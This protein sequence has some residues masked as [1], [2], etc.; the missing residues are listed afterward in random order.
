MPVEE[1]KGQ[2]RQGQNKALMWQP[3]A[4]QGCRG[5]QP[6]QRGEDESAGG[7]GW[8]GR[9]VKATLRS[10]GVGRA[11]RPAQGFQRR[12][13]QGHPSSSAHR[14]ALHPTTVPRPSHARPRQ[15]GRHLAGRWASAHISR[16]LIS[17]ARRRRAQGN[18]CLNPALHNYSPSAWQTRPVSEP[19]DSKSIRK[20]SEKCVTEAPGGLESTRRDHSSSR[21]ARGRRRWPCRGPG[22]AVGRTPAHPSGRPLPCGWL[23][24][25]TLDGLLAL[26][27]LPA[28]LG[29]TPAR[30]HGSRTASHCLGPRTPGVSD[31][32]PSGGG[33][34]AT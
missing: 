19:K 8:K 20:A 5:A 14:P 12:P 4:P 24:P 7:E 21:D 11:G 13:W 34:W 6:G 25:A 9:A 15:P 30:A 10:G 23:T 22:P 16:F 1:R 3:R 17:A 32:A 29:R 33:D 31:C 27:H 2:P 28:Y 26:R 18:R